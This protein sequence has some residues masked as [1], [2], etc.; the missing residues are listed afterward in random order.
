MAQS[1]LKDIVGGLGLTVLGTYVLLTA[2]DL[3]IAS[4]TRMGAGYFPMML[5]VA[6]IISGLLIF[7][8]ALN[9]PDTPPRIAWRSLF[10]VVAGMTGFLLV[11]DRFG[12][13]PAICVL[14]AIA[15]LADRGSTV[16]GTVV[17]MLVISMAA[18]LVFR[19]ALGLPLPGFVGL[20]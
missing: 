20:G 2:F 11:V 13:V 8:P 10:A 1:N 6:L 3:G 18:W 16:R 17:L 15:A 9:T 4:A 7:L 19:V 14:I 5:G 12:L